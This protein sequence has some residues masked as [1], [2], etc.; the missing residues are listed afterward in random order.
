[1]IVLLV[2]NELENMRKEASVAKIHLLFQYSL[3][4]RIEA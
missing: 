4:Y 1:M 3:E 2:N